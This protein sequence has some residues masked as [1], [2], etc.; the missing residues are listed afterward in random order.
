MSFPRLVAAVATL[1]LAA[2]CSSSS[3]NQDKGLTA[4]GDDTIQ[5]HDTNPDGVPYP[6]DHLGFR[7]R[8]NATV[9]TAP[10]GDRI[11]NFKFLG[12]PDADISKGLQ[13]V[14]L[15]D[16]Y[17][18]EGKKY[19]IIHVSVSGVW[20]EW[21]IAET[22][23]LV[24]LVPQLKDKKVVYLT[25]LSE[26]IRHA[27]A[28]QKDLDFWINTYH[29]NYTQLLDPGNRN[30]GPF[31]TSA[32]IPWNGNIDARSMEVLSSITSAP[33]TDGVTIDIMGDI[34]PWLDWYDNNPAAYAVH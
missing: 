30:L 19:K 12:Y 24:P 2:A 21:C 23:A 18:P 14:A 34:Q 11:Q 17:D 10:P 4:G 31:F 33:S 5:G 1:A 20:C 22:K 26:D 13:P 3:K 7:A 8:N 16:Y 32:G 6:A 25:A 27:P 28:Q 15:A 29:P 9:T